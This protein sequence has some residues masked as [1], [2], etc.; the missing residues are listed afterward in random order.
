MPVCITGMHRSGTS[1]VARMLNLAGLYLGQSDRIMPAANDNPNG[2]WEHL[3]FVQINDE[4]LS[5][6]GGS[7]D[8]IPQLPEDWT[9]A[10]L[11]YSIR[12][13]ASDL[14]KEMS[15]ISPWGWKDPRNSITYPF[16]KIL[17][18]EMK[19]VF[20]LR[21]PAEVAFSLQ[22]RNGF[23]L[24][25]GLNL[26]YEYNKLLL[27]AT[28][29]AQRIITHYDAYF[30][31]SKAELTRLLVWLNWQADEK[32]IAEAC[33]ALAAN[34]RHH[35]HASTTVLDS[36]QFGH[37]LELYQS[38]SEEAAHRDNRLNK[39]H[40]SKRKEPANFAFSFPGETN[41][42]SEENCLAPN[43]SP[44]HKP[45][46]SI[47]I[48][49]YDQLDFTRSCLA[50]LV[51]N[52]GDQFSY[53]VI[54]VN[55]G[56]DNETSAYLN[57][58][59][60]SEASF[61]LVANSANLGFSRGCNI[62][63]EHARG[64]YLVFLNNDTE[65][66]TGW[67][68]NLI[69]PFQ[70]DEK[71]GIA[72]AK[73]LYADGTI[74]HAGIGFLPLDRAISLGN[75]GLIL[76]AP[77]HEY[78]FAPADAPEVNEFKEIDMVTGACL[79]VSAE[80]FR[81]V[82][83][84]D[85]GYLNGCEDADLCLRIRDLALKVVYNP[86]AVLIHHERKSKIRYENLLPNLGRFFMLWGH[87]FDATWRF[88]P[89]Y[90]AL[91]TALSESGRVAYDEIAKREIS[92]ENQLFENIGKEVQNNEAVAE[93]D[94]SLEKYLQ[95]LNEFPHHAMAHN[96]LAVLCYQTGRIAE[97]VHHLQIAYR[98]DNE[99]LNIKKNLADLYLQLNFPAEAIKI[100]NQIL[101]ANPDDIEVLS[102]LAALSEQFQDFDTAMQLLQR[103]EKID[104]DNDVWKQ[105]II[106]ITG[107]S[108]PES[109]AQESRAKETSPMIDIIDQYDL[110]KCPICEAPTP[111][112]LLKHQHKYYQCPACRSIFTPQI[113]SS[114]LRTENNGNGGRHEE[115][116]DHIRLNRL[117]LV[118]K[119]KIKKMVDFGCGEGEYGQFVKEQGIACINIDQDTEIQLP[120]LQEK[121]VDAI[122]MVEVI[123]HIIR[124]EALFREFNRVLKRSGVVY[125]ESSFYEDQE[126]KAWSY[127]DPRIGHCLIHTPKSIS[128]LAKNTGFSLQK[129]NSNCYAFAKIHDLADGR[130]DSHIPKTK[131]HTQKEALDSKQGKMIDKNG[132]FHASIII[133]LFNKVEY[134]RKC[135]EAIYQNTGS[136]ISFEVILVDNA[137]SDGTKKYLA[138]AK[139]RYPNL[140]FIRNEKNL[141]FARACNQGAKMAKGRYLVF[142]NN[143]TEP[144]SGWLRNAISRFA[145]DEKI[146]IVG[147]KLLY[148]DR[149]I[150]HCGIE[151]M[152]N[153]NPE[154]RFWPLHRFRTASED[155]P[156][157]IHPEE[158][159]AVTGACLFIPRRLFKKV[160]GFTE[161]YGMYFEDTDLCFKVRKEGKSICYEPSSV[162]IHHEG[163]SSPDQNVIDELNRKAAGI[164]YRRWAAEMLR[165]ELE[166]KI[167]KQDQKFLYLK[168][169]L[170]PEEYNEGDVT[171]TAL[172]LGRLFQAFE[173]FYAHFGGVGDA[174]LLLS[175][176][177]DKKPAQTIVS[178]ASSTNTLRSFFEAFPEISKVYF[179]PRPEND[180]SHALLRKIFPNLNNCQGM[181]V[182]PE[183]EF[184]EDEWVEN[185]DIFSKYKVTRRPLWI[186]QFRTEKLEK[187]QVTI[188][189]R[190]SV[191][192]MVGSKRNVID[193]EQWDDLLRFFKLQEI[194]PVLLGTPDENSEYPAVHGAIDKRSYNFREQMELIASSDLF[195]GA[196]SWAKTMAG[197]A[198]V[199]TIVFHAV[200]DADLEGWQDSS[201]FVFIHPWESICL[202]ENIDE[203]RG[204]CDVVIPKIR[205]VR[206]IE[207]MK[208]LSPE[209]KHNKYSKAGNNH[210]YLWREGGIGDVLMALPTARA[211]KTKYPGCKITFVTLSSNKEIV[212]AN[213]W[214]DE[215]Y[216]AENLF[217]LKS[218][219]PEIHD[220]NPVEFGIKPLHQVD[221]FLRKF[222]L[223]LPRQKKEIELQVPSEIKNKVRELVKAKIYPLFGEHAAAKPRIILIHAAKGDRNRTWPG[224][225]WETLINMVLS[226]NHVPVLVGSDSTDPAR[227]VFRFQREGTVDLV[228]QLSPLEFVAL[229]RMCDLLISTDSGPVQLAAASDI[230]IAGIYSVVSGQNRLP[231]RH[232]ILGWNA[233]AIESGCKFNSCYKLLNDEKHNKKLKA[234]V[235][236]Q[237]AT[238]GELFG[239]WCPADV[240]YAC[241]EKL[242]P[243]EIVWMK[244]KS[245]LEA[246]KSGNMWKEAAHARKLDRATLPEAK[247]P[248]PADQLSKIEKMYDEAL[249]LFQ[250]NNYG[251]AIIRLN[252]II[253]PRP[254]FSRAY[255]L[256]GR[257][258]FNLGEPEDALSFFKIAIEKDP[259]FIAAQHEYGKCLA[260][261]NRIDE[262]RQAFA[263]ILKNHPDDVESRKLLENLAGNVENKMIPDENTNH[264]RDL[265]AADPEFLKTRYRQLR[266][267]G[268]SDE[269]IKALA[270][271]LSAQPKDSEALNEMG[272][273]CFRNRQPEL[274]IRYFEKAVSNNGTHPEHLKN[275]AD[276]YLSQ[277]RFE[278]GITILLQL[279]KQF[280]HDFE[281]HE[282]LANLYF[283]DG[284]ANTARDIISRYLAKN[285][286]DSYARSVYDLMEDPSIYV[287][288]QL[289]N[290]G[291]LNEAEEVL[292]KVLLQNPSSLH[293]KLG[294]GSILFANENFE[295]AEATY[296]EILE[297]FPENEEAIYYLAKIHLIEN[298]YD[299]LEDHFKQFEGLLKDSQNLQ[300]IWIESLLKQEQIEEASSEVEKYLRK[301]PDDPEALLISGNLFY[302]QGA[303]GKARQQ[304]VKALKLDPDNEL[305]KE[306][307][308][309]LTGA[310]EAG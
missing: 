293:A 193:P 203:F 59:A 210:F 274:A 141:K 63:A 198:S 206:P 92:I 104:P 301:Y 97:S 159:Q 50:K 57:S 115:G 161:D 127:L 2:F 302:E 286:E 20:A 246:G 45:V 215:F 101:G 229:C 110:Q 237:K 64:K 90:S 269:F 234:R 267:Q 147:S 124:P 17:V 93:S 46:V 239:K 186:K 112:V 188:H 4:I 272:A 34:L 280:P 236:E 125:I 248:V 262:A 263:T 58:V 24:E 56:S 195:V 175:T 158:V 75:Y 84:F 30:Q 143:D 7:W 252:R 145:E 150:Q 51:Q 192:G 122:N 14:I 107:Q 160:R 91:D 209:K 114:I 261:L 118:S 119:E 39:M 256:L 225:N 258:S 245:L 205:A 172:E 211:L 60:E 278:Q 213:P 196:D 21:N 8:K 296:R 189:P 126:P 285:I 95:F 44:Q 218:R 154:Y 173:P 68:E 73:L 303:P 294:L 62:G 55:N 208:K 259:S 190:G 38:L 187:F 265:N 230:A 185:I 86:E 113:D 128:L 82:G 271:Y 13:K 308:Q 47:I 291:R 282:K 254:D 287:A 149:T 123:E 310:Q 284:D 241:M 197:L 146:G 170:F 243:A 204:I 16:W 142:L 96:E 306:N 233:V 26:W 105:K 299:E 288:F 191:K 78:R 220:L 253:E 166:S 131:K 242:I 200:R 70:A 157:V 43:D 87:R 264:D 153:V 138:E 171:K 132:N 108:K 23:S 169:D 144:E 247:R 155:D 283:E 151:F 232:G 19:V 5:F 277:E 40:N 15:L 61:N 109:E 235:K 80:N 279:M 250:K 257:I 201:D 9:S 98:L 52:T 199:P 53:E 238:L 130:Q 139:Q 137:S 273:V 179:I 120:E 148:P 289:I 33:S 228:N 116:S 194:R 37:V 226:E 102:V 94:A 292:R 217:Q 183:N 181:G 140:K 81:N 260:R 221:A 49:V 3:D 117:R 32:Q 76:V 133:P 129:I 83:G 249:S 223:S 42:I 214:V 31:D 18:P 268:K 305:I 304:Y 28:E 163:K 212:L 156:S 6:F 10:P 168:K 100:Y 99:N 89:N 11:L 297:D 176:F 152:E 300:K 227:G 74:Q 270:D 85:E 67:L 71:V 72:G 88:I 35:Q 103:L 202:V 48:P 178:I 295:E 1:M 174:L 167:E 266:D 111:L 77:D 164:F 275:L 69:R 240:K 12:K 177:Y 207:S 307:L 27:S 162:V 255:H 66:Q 222:G 54:L 251:E 65:P 165:I 216:P 22:R 309:F 276:A 244:S 25:Y 290:S 36:K 281:A 298:K 224:K 134:T 41:R 79:A 219:V 135:I 121:S 136:E 180:I 184:Y 106:Q 231:Y 29:P 182:A